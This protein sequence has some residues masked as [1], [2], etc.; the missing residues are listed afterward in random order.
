MGDYDK[1]V[2]TSEPLGGDGPAWY[3]GI[4]I[5]MGAAPYPRDALTVQDFAKEH[6]PEFA[7]SILPIPSAEEHAALVECVERAREVSRALSDRRANHAMVLLDS[8]IS[9]LDA[10]RKERGA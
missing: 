9:R 6:F 8:A 2:W 10:A 7:R 4:D 1:S 3:W 5:V